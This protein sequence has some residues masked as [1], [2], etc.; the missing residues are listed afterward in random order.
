VNLSF[1][2]TEGK[3]SICVRQGSTCFSTDRSPF[4]FHRSKET[5]QLHVRFQINASL[6]GQVQRVKRVIDSREAV[7]TAFTYTSTP[8]NTPISPS[9]STMKILS[10]I[11][12]QW[13]VPPQLSI[14]PFFFKCFCEYTLMLFFDH[15]IRVPCN[16]SYGIWAVPA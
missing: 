14:H 8:R 6:F 7:L 9:G 2:L 1:L 13:N 5:I 4:W 16:C 10:S 11:A 15:A 12:S 3:V